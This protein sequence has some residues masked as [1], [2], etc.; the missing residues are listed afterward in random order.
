MKKFTNRLINENSP[1]LLQ[2]ANNPVDWYPWNDDALTKAKKE[3]KP[4]FLSI[5]YS[6]CHWCHVMAHESFEDE[7]ISSILNENFINI[8]VDR[9]E[10]P[11]IDDVYQKVCQLATGNGG[12]PL[13]V[14]LTPDQKPFYV[15]TYFPKHARYGI[16]GFGDLLESLS[17][18]YK[19]KSNEV[20]KATSEFMNSLIASSGNLVSKEN[21]LKIDRSILKESASN[22]LQIADPLH[23][24]FGQSPKFPNTSNLLF[25]LR[26][27]DLSGNTQFLNFVEF[28]ATKMLQGGIHDHV[29]GGFARYSTD[30]KWLV[31]HFEKM[32]Y[33]NA[34]LVQLYSELF[35]ITKKNKYLKLVN[36]ILNYVIK[37]MT[38]HDLSA[39]YSAQDADSE[40]EEGKYYVWKKQEIDD[41]LKDKK[42]S[43]IFCEYF[44]ITE[45]G[46][47]EGKNILNITSSLEYF[48]KKHNMSTIDMENL[49]DTHLSKLYEIRAKRIPPGLD[50]KILTSW[51][52]LMISAFV[53]GY[54]VTNNLEYYMFARNAIQFIESKL[55]Y[56]NYR[57]LRTFKNDAGKLNGY[58]DDYA[59][60]I[61]SLL[62]FFSID[63]DYVYLE[64]AINYTNSMIEYYW[65]QKND[66][67][68]FT[69]DDHE[70]LIVRSK[71]FYDLAIPSGNSMAAYIL[72]RLYRITNNENYYKKALNIMESC[73]RAARENPFG[74]GQLLI[75]IYQY[76]QEPLEILIFKNKDINNSKND[77]SKKTDSE[78][79][80]DKQ[81]LPNAIISII[82]IKNNDN[83]NKLSSY[84]LFNQLNKNLK[85]SSYSY[86]ECVL[87]CKNFSCSL[88]LYDLDQ[89]KDYFEK[90]NIIKK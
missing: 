60:Y 10:R 72:L 35:Q 63:S 24:G 32:L 25:L 33:D 82:D 90:E 2:H 59:Y 85:D 39:F 89:L 31:P 26:Y 38:S 1:Y 66:N 34:L 71:N 55:K 21:M 83:M 69:S 7:N 16:P 56:N 14:F 42:L 87:V 19:T 67:F 48:S 47:F 13:S 36:K 81:Y 78:L 9:E 45:G 61:N 18:T 37:E 70:N 73:S 3:N 51:N 80:I 20:E 50:D 52:A 88:P 49:L 6:S 4:I 30:Q 15:G 27:Y 54:K 22:L 79:W 84:S 43:D 11:D 77:V 64:K 40:G 74:F 23:G 5:G 28:T 17:Q 46:N 57:L 8:K 41:I 58:L 53:S 75:S 12:W 65:D 76:L 29:G 68:F 62:D 86:D 44:N